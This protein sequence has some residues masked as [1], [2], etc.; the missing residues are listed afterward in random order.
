MLKGI[1]MELGRDFDQPPYT[2]VLKLVAAA[3]KILCD[4]STSKLGS[5]ETH[6]LMEKQLELFSGLRSLSVMSH[7]SKF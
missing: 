3:A 4:C 6:E 5:V 2:P 7:L 1:A